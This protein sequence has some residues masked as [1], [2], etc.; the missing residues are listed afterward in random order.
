MNHKFIKPD[1]SYSICQIA[2]I[3]QQSLSDAIRF[4]KRHRII[5]DIISGKLLFRGSD[6][7]RVFKN[8]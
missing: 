4:V 7:L 3:F 8:K 1:K 2:T 6:I 5:Y